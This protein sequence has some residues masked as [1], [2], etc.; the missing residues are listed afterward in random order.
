MIGLR[1][2]LEAGVINRLTRLLCDQSLVGRAAAARSLCS[3]GMRGGDAVWDIIVTADVMSGLLSAIRGVG[4]QLMALAT[5]VGDSVDEVQDVL[6]L[7]LDL[8]CSVCESS[9]KAVDSFN[10]LGL[11][12]LHPMAKLMEQPFIAK[13]PHAANAAAQCLHVLSE[14][15]AAVAAAIGSSAPTIHII[16]SVFADAASP[17]VIAVLCAGILVNLGPAAYPPDFASSLQRVLTAALATDHYSALPQLLAAL[18]AAAT[19]A[20]QPEASPAAQ[21]PA[22]GGGEPMSATGDG[23]AGA[24][25]RRNLKPVSHGKFQEQFLHTEGAAA[26]AQRGL[27]AWTDGVVTAQIGLQLLANLMSGDGGDGGD[28]SDDEGWE[29][30]GDEDGMHPADDDGGADAAAGGAEEVAGWVMSSGLLGRL[31]LLAS[32]PPAEAAAAIAAAGPAG[33]NVRRRLCELQVP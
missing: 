17:L 16:H 21:E 1:V 10:V 6:V 25:G 29:S 20:L 26:A 8:L 19:G 13:F 31:C 15:N 28:G 18:H 7:L 23:V 33:L 9:C 12:L 11:D 27:D 4:G 24:G 30:A 32:Y 2:L 14:D 5:Q 3:I 22:G